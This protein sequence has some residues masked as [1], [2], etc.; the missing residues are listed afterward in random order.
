MFCQIPYS[1]VYSDPSACE[2][3]DEVLYGHGLCVTGEE[4]DGFVPVLTEGGERGFVRKEALT[5]GRSQT[6]H[7][8]AER[9]ALVLEQA[10]VKS[11]VLA[12]LPRFS[13]VSGKQE[14][15]RFIRVFLLDGREGFVLSPQLAPARR[16]RASREDAVQTALSLLGVSYRWGGR[17]ER[18]LDCS[19][20]VHLCFS[21]CGF[22]LPRSTRGMQALESVEKKDVRRGD[23]ILFEDHVG[24][25]LT[26]T[27]FIHASENFG[28]VGISSVSE[29]EELY[30]S[31][32]VARGYVFKRVTTEKT[33]SR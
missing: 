18:G 29:E 8:T 13:R 10:A 12:V 4:T 14:N 17:S 19:G 30:D 32:H 33:E 20:L 7:F 5:Q 21:A 31:E 25:M 24:L 16:A 27:H 15:A 28:C 2:M 3:V 6:F 22:C 1:E 11:R 26:R 23:L 9:D